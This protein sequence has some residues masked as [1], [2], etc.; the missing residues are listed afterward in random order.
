MLLWLEKVA[1]K[2]VEMGGHTW[3]S[4]IMPTPVLLKEADN[5]DDASN[6]DEG[7]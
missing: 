7:N 6:A 1:Y 3:E 4:K 2:I 5:A